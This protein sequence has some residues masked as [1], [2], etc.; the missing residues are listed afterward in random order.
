MVED[1]GQN[2]SS[3]DLSAKLM[4]YK[5]RAIIGSITA[6]STEVGES[7][8]ADY[9]AEAE[10][11]LA[12]ADESA[13][14]SKTLQAL[15]TLKELPEQLS[16]AR[17]VFSR[18]EDVLG[19]Y[20]DDKMTYDE[21]MATLNNVKE[22]A[23]NSSLYLYREMLDAY[24]KKVE[25]KIDELKA[26]KGTESESVDQ[27]SGDN[28]G[29]DQG[30]SSRSQ[31]TILISGVKSFH[32]VARDDSFATGNEKRLDDYIA[33]VKQL[34]KGHY[35]DLSDDDIDR[36]LRDPSDE[37]IDKRLKDTANETIGKIEAL[38]GPFSIAIDIKNKVNEVYTRIEKKEGYTDSD[39]SEL[40]ALVKRITEAGVY[41]EAL[42]KHLE[43][44][45]AA[46]LEYNKSVDVD[47]ERGKEREVC[48]SGKEA[49]SP[50]EIKKDL[51][52]LLK[53]IDEE[54]LTDE[55]KIRLNELELEA[56]QSPEPEYEAVHTVI[57]VEKR[58]R[59]LKPLDDESVKY[60]QQLAEDIAGRLVQNLKDIHPDVTKKE[61][62]Q[63][64]IKEFD[65]KIK[66]TQ[67][68]YESYR[69]GLT[70]A[71]A[72]VYEAIVK[73]REGF[74]KRHG[75]VG[76]TEGTTTE[77]DR[78]QQK[79]ELK[80]KL[81]QYGELAAADE[82]NID[83]LHRLQ[84]EIDVLKSNSEGDS[85]LM[86]IMD[87]NDVSRRIKYLIKVYEE[88]GEAD[89]ETREIISVAQQPETVSAVGG[90]DSSLRERV[91]NSFAATLKKLRE[92]RGTVIPEAEE[93]P[94]EE[95]DAAYSVCDREDA[96]AMYQTGEELGLRSPTEETPYMK[97]RGEI[98]DLV[99]QIRLSS[100]P[101]RIKSL[102]K[103]LIDLKRKARDDAYSEHRKELLDLIKK[104]DGNA[105]QKQK[106]LL[107]R[108]GLK[109]VLSAMYLKALQ[110][111]SYFTGKRETFIAILKEKVSDRNIVRFGTDDGITYYDYDRLIQWIDSNLDQLKDEV[112]SRFA[113]EKG[114]KDKEEELK[115]RIGDQKNG[116]LGII[117]GKESPNFNYQSIVNAYE[118]LEKIYNRA[119]TGFRSPNSGLDKEVIDGLEAL[120]KDTENKI[121]NFSAT[122]EAEVR[123]KPVIDEGDAVAI[124][125]GWEEFESILEEIKVNCY[126]YLGFRDINEFVEWENAP[127]D[128]RNQA[129]N[130]LLDILFRD[131]NRNVIK[132]QI[133]DKTE[134]E[135]I[136]RK[137][138]RIAEENGFRCPAK[139]YRTQDEDRFAAQLHDFKREI[140]QHIDQLSDERVRDI[141]DKLYNGGQQAID[142]LGN[143]RNYYGLLAR[144]GRQVIDLETIDDENEFKRTLDAVVGEGK[145]ELEFFLDKD[146]NFSHLL[147][148]FEGALEDLKDTRLNR[149]AKKRNRRN[150]LMGAGIYSVLA[151]LVT[152]YFGWF[153]KPEKV[154]VV[155]P[156]ELGPRVSALETEKAD[157]QKRLNEAVA[158]RD[159]YK[160]KAE[161]EAQKAK[162]LKDN[163]QDEVDKRITDVQTKNTELEDKVKSLQGE[164]G[165]VSDSLE[166]E[167]ITRG[168]EKIEYE[169]K[170]VKL[171]GELAGIA[172]K[173]EESK[174][175]PDKKGVTEYEKQLA[176]KEKAMVAK[177][178]ALAEKEKALKEAMVAKAEP[179]QESKSIQEALRKQVVELEEEIKELKKQIPA[180]FD[181]PDAEKI[182]HGR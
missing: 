56:R 142:K 119:Q 137:I 140:T 166:K 53:K 77:K 90:G 68:S 40:D 78:E 121:R 2:F 155:R 148:E 127:V 158:A 52:E 182:L 42:K 123:G 91:V 45:R 143:V 147:E 116:L 21:V 10:K 60:R 11:L 6:E 151:T 175:K 12:G 92:K 144:L 173:L 132:S 48:E 58:G 63:W 104:E 96:V 136:Y 15:K 135:E 38:R 139:F 125:N 55:Y 34:V 43:D 111:Q 64:I 150:L 138:G 122:K 31:L 32:N 97:F 36:V 62:S 47:V 131:V 25:K 3:E 94:E 161:A 164:L 180:D 114:R 71:S 100:D 179:E 17:A 168:E 57:R 102:R 19:A 5:N 103:E 178:K 22:R 149:N 95:R 74:L 93:K 128:D 169:A 106:G 33:Q 87:E 181:H 23:K 141:F 107:N 105:N 66:L 26:T 59:G 134:K 65:K 133:K 170:I 174:T 85:E 167:R 108:V 76:K 14:S 172:R 176:E 109:E 41:S 157:L 75:Y 177:E 117:E 44:T 18:A 112:N 24:V 61:I 130:T 54:G 153:A 120:A 27:P 86:Q 84:D 28:G 16:S 129:E 73:D 165:K 70:K 113:K 50:S 83:F 118:R 1:S 49:R 8:I 67:H 4:D 72:E 160:S 51:D 80:E 156:V 126:L 101:D 145:K 124:G 69:P 35:S 163:I 13:L 29:T 9:R 110:K 46:V 99:S 152:A 162:K 88:G 30:I 146:R 98:D 115:D 159:E 39:I 89:E 81:K 7:L 37:T 20:K 79:Q 154:E 82:E 171:Q